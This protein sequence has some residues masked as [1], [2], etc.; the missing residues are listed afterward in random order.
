M[1]NNLPVTG[2][3]IIPTRLTAPSPNPNNFVLVQSST[4]YNFYYIIGGLLL[5]YYFSK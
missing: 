3:T 2:G 4:N 5:L 1:N